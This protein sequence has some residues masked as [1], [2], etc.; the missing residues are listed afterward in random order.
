VSVEE[1]LPEAGILDVVRAAFD[2]AAVAKP[3][4]ATGSR[5]NSDGAR[6]RV[7]FP[8]FHCPRGAYGG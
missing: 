4:Q 3:G 6:Q 1:W 7:R 5:D 8:G 2:P